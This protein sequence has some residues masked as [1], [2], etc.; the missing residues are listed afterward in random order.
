MTPQLAAVFTANTDFAETEVDVRQLNLTRFPLFFPERRSF[1][2]EGSNQFDFGLGLGETFIPFFSRRVGLLEGRQVPIQ[3]GVKLDGRAGRWNQRSNARYLLRAGRQSLCGPPLGR[4]QPRTASRR[5]PDRRRSRRPRRRLAH[6]AV[7]W[8]QEPAHRWLDCHDTPRP[9]AGT[10]LRLGYK[11]DYPNDRWDCMNAVFEFGEALN[12]R[13]LA[14]PPDRE[15]IAI[16][17]RWTF[18][19]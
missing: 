14:L 19:P 4:C 11:I 3:G 13:D 18:R 7:P 1:F 6:I 5:H 15:F 12:P 8:R 16:K 17:L 10:A 9:H 2:L